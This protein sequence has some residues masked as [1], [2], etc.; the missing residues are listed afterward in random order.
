M[1]ALPTCA[2]KAVSKLILYKSMRWG[3]SFDQHNYTDSTSL[4]SAFTAWSRLPA[5][6]QLKK[7]QEKYSKLNGDAERNLAVLKALI[8]EIEDACVGETLSTLKDM[9]VTSG[10][11]TDQVLGSLR[12]RLQRAIYKI[13]SEA[14]DEMKR[15]NR[16]VIKLE[17]AYEE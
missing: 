16:E 12:Q 9:R 3:I 14:A 5:V 8:H 2:H 15:R 1:R 17:Q 4:K 13:N 6:Q 10:Q 11:A 7:E